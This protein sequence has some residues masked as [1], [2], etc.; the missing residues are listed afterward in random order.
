[1]DASGYDFTSVFRWAA[2]FLVLAGLV[3]GVFVGWLVF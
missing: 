2:T 1:M 3:V